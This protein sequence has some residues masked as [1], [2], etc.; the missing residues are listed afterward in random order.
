MPLWYVSWGASAYC[1]IIGDTYSLFGCGRSSDEGPGIKIKLRIAWSL[2]LSS[3]HRESVVLGAG[4]VAVL[5][6]DQGTYQEYWPPFDR[7]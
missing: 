1:R 4:T 5:A 6:E 2:A 7:L 3:T